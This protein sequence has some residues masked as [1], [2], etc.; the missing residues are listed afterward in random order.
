MAEIPGMAS[1][2]ARTQ[3][4]DLRSFTPAGLERQ[5]QVQ[6]ARAGAQI[7]NL[8]AQIKALKAPDKDSKAYAG[9]V[10]QKA[11]LEKRLANFQEQA[12]ALNLRLQGHYT[13]TG[14]Y[15]KLLT[16]ETRDAYLAINSLFKSYG[17]ESLAG[18]IY[19]YVKNGYSGDTISILLQ[20]TDEYKTR[21]AGN[22]E[23]IKAGLPV[24]SPAEYLATEASYRQIMQQA[25]L[26]V[27]FYDTPGDFAGWIGKNVSPSEIQSRVDLATQATVLANPSY[28]QALNQIGISDGQLTAYFLDPTKALPNL[29]K[30]AATAAIGSEAIQQ[31]LA[32]NQSYAEQLALSGVTASQARQ[33]YQQVA[34]ELGTLTNIGSMYGEEWT[35][36]EGAEAVFGTSANAVSQRASLVGKERGAFGGA[37]GTA[38]SGLGQASQ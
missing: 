28:R 13:S 32:F 15:E 35:Q 27:G 5:L 4:P 2:L 7:K 33:G 1:A 18:K 17:L 11:L 37:T 3:R 23:R 19:E 34:Q 24:L 10:K 16:G 38:K 25:G 21:F 8:Q 31:G 30:T 20:D 36:Q 29:Q 22:Q 12:K 6:I 9:Y 14:Q 26:P